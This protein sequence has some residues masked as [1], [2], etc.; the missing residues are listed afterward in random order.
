MRSS[1][2]SSV[3]R[4]F[5]VRVRSILQSNFKFQL[6]RA[7]AR[8]GRWRSARSA[9]AL[10][11]VS[12]G[13]SPGQLKFE[14]GKNFGFRRTSR[15]VANILYF[16][17]HFGQIP[18]FSENLGFSGKARISA[19]I[20]DFSENLGFR[21]KSRISSKISDLGGKSRIW[22]TLPPLSLTLLLRSPEKTA[23]DV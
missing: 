11:A 8:P 10:A 12:G 2:R 13:S 1:V 22:S 17:V 15:I 9:A 5:V 20:S 3:R 7:G 21:R 18:N 19:K 16:N 4:P 6:A 23:K 14:I